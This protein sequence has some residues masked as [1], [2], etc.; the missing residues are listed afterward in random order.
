ML[1]NCAWG[2]LIGEKIDMQIFP[3]I[4]LHK[5]SDFVPVKFFQVNNDNMSMKIYMEIFPF[6]DFNTTFLTVMYMYFH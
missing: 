5:K 1:K 2:L 3:I 6:I 4:N